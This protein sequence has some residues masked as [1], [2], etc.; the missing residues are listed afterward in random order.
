MYM[1]ESHPRV[2]VVVPVYCHTSDH[3]QYLREALESVAGQ[4]FRDFEVIIVDDVSPKDIA[5]I[6]DSVN[7]LPDVTIL[8]NVLNVGH[9]QSR[10]AGVRA[11]RGEF[12]AFLDHDDIWM[13]GKLARQI[14]IMDANP[15]AAMVFCDMITFGEHA[16]R[17]NIDQSIIPARPGFYW[18]VAHGNFTIS[19]SAVLIKRQ[20][21]LD[22][23]LFDDR[24]STCDDFD[25]WLKALML[26]PV[27]HLPEKLAKYRLHGSNVNYTVDRLNDNILL[28]ALIW[29]YWRVAPIADKIRLLPRLARKYVG[30]AYFTIRRFRTFEN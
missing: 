14:E 15:D 26:A 11:A 7:N 27:V 21:M 24:Y 4:S 29:R 22:I 20:I 6:I 5:P 28:T 12:V 18:F 8:R 17:L 1:V 16:G 30:R 2:S 13:P 3:A 19:A 23:G 25:A 9:A 10:N